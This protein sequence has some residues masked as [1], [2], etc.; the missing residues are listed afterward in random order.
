MAGGRFSISMS[1]FISIVTG[2]VFVIAGGAMIAVVH[3]FM[4][5]ESIRQATVET[6][7]I[8]N[9][10]LATH[11]YFTNELKPD[12]FAVTDSLYGDDY[13]DPVWMSSSYVVRKID[14]HFRE[15]YADDF[16]YKECAINARQPFNEADDYERA[17]LLELNENSALF[18][19]TDIRV[20]DGAP[21]F[22]TMRRGEAMESSCLRCHSTPEAAPA[23]MVAAYGAVRGFDWPK[24]GTVSAVSI[25]IPLAEAYSITRRY[26]LFLSAFV[27]MIL[28][29]VYV[30][31]FA[32][33]SRSLIGPLGRIRDTALKTARD[34]ENLGTV[35]EEPFGAELRDM[36]TAFNMMSASLKEERDRLEEKVRERT[37]RLAELNKELSRDIERREAL[38]REREA[39]IDDLSNALAQVKQLKG[40][41][42]ICASCKRVRDDGGYWMQI[43]EYIHSHSEAEF[44][45]GICPECARKLYPEYME[46][47]NNQDSETGTT[48]P[49][50]GNSA[51]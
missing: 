32:V 11:H 3:H 6:T 46:I 23:G 51:T 13:F 48:K 40:L 7:I 44:S 10:N 35:I 26:T 34:S 43:E 47:E 45:H 36:T 9:R 37:Q 8:L 2:I 18:E 27:I 22:I 30:T 31:T 17:F 1:L 24:S 21:Y 14:A 19:K 12:L 33:V 49:P 16:Y 39:L 29:G 4:V 41:L 25:R 20:I 42:P 28:V 38:E 15:M 50:E 5:E